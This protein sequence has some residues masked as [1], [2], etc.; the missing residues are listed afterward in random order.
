MNDAIRRLF[1]ITKNYIYM[2]HAGVSPLPGPSVEAMNRQ[3]LQV[4]THGT[5]A[6]NDWIAGIEKTREKIAKLVNAKPGEIAFMRNTSDGL[7]V[8]A[9]G[10]NWKSGDNVVTC[11]C[12]FPANIY[13]WMRFER[14]GVEV[15]MAHERQ[16][17]VEADELL[18]L[19]DGRTR[20]VAVSFVQFASGFRMDLERIGAVCRQR[21]VLF[22]VDAIQG[23]GALEFDVEK[24]HVDAFSADGHK[25]LLGPEG[26]AVM[27]VS[28]RALDRIQPTVV[29]WM[30]VKNW[31]DAVAG[32]RISYSLEYLDGAARFESGTLNAIGIHGLGASLDILL[33]V[34]IEKIETHVLALGDRLCE[35]LQSKGY[36]V[37]SSRR[38]QEASCIV[39]TVKQGIAAHELAKHLAK[40][41]IIVAARCGRLRFAP[42]VYNTFEEVETVVHSLP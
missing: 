24:F 3:A 13:P 21:D 31:R 11:D 25:W 26:C 34:G 37:T 22:V 7:S 5:E 8:I 1:P 6:Y 16:G 4:A 14:D 29:G 39:C 32:D 18:S 40:N 19:I 9:N 28:E 33:D 23:L 35:G 27:F 38:P 20:V 17:R 41:R 36:E 15:R 12:E 10:I 42:H 2:N 30:S